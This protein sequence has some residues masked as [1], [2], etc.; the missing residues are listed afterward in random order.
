[1]VAWSIIQVCPPNEV[2]TLVPVLMRVFNTRHALMDFL[3]TLIDR[4]VA[5]AG[6]SYCS[7]AL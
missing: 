3:K 2:E 7:L 5:G 4:E 6:R 1:M